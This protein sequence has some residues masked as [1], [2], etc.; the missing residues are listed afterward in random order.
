MC[1]IAQSFNNGGQ[2]EEYE[3]ERLQRH[4][5]HASRSARAHHAGAFA[6]TAQMCSRSDSV[7]SPAVSQGH[8]TASPASTIPSL[9]CSAMPGLT[10]LPPSRAAMRASARSRPRPCPALACDRLCCV[11]V[12]A[13]LCVSLSCSS[14]L[15]GFACLLVFVFFWD[16]RYIVRLVVCS[17]AASQSQ[18]PPSMPGRLTCDICGVRYAFP[19]LVVV[20]CRVQSGRKSVA[21]R[22]FCFR[23]RLLCPPPIL[24]HHITSCTQHT[25]HANH[26]HRLHPHATRT[27]RR[28]PHTHCTYHTLTI[29]GITPPTPRTFHTHHIHTT[30]HPLIT[31]NHPH[32]SH[33]QI[34]VFAHASLRWHTHY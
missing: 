2:G 22:L 21:S 8:S 17:A 3:D 23:S 28:A 26:I 4:V 18:R 27:T 1:G 33:Y 5:L 16:R 32:Q 25:P 14:V 31:H 29:P 15:A 30:P 19:V 13:A 9:P 20:L 12:D 34:L 24:S 6:D 7:L 11:C 10:L